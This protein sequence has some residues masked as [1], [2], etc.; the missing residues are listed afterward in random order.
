MKGEGEWGSDDDLDPHDEG[1]EAT[2]LQGASAGPL[3][4]RERN[5]NPNLCRT[6]GHTTT[7][8]GSLAPSPVS[9]AACLLHSLPG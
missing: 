2:T 7:T 5:Q 1:D 4:S 3:T 9:P 6:S 8:H